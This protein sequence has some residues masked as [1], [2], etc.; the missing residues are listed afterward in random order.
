MTFGN[1]KKAALAGGFALGVLAVPTMV[2][3]APPP[4]IAVDVDYVCGDGGASIVAS[5]VPSVADDRDLSMFVEIVDQGEDSSGRYDD[6]FDLEPGT[7][8]FPDD[9]LEDGDTD[10]EGPYADGSY[11]VIVEVE[12]NDASSED[13]D[14]AFLLVNLEIDCSSLP[15][16]TTDEPA[17]TTPGAAA[18]TTAVASGGNT[19]PETGGS[20]STLA[21]AAL[22]FV[23]LGTA[24]LFVR[25]GRTA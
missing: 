6:Y 16:A 24:L 12:D 21:V 10:V 22:V 5:A 20:S 13:D 18:P 11:R 8:T 14:A 17:T 23:G 9:G 25:R 2:S 1:V 15:P 3:A 4:P 19:L 7:Y